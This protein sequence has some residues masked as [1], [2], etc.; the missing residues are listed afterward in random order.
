MAD[1]R[2]TVRVTWTR[3]RA[4]KVEGPSLHRNQ[5]ILF[6]MSLTLKRKLRDNK[7]HPWS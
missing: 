7:S 2:G 6:Y 4:E 1:V 5:K 3:A